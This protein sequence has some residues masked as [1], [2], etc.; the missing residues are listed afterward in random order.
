M[1]NPSQARENDEDAIGKEQFLIEE[2]EPLGRDANKFFN[3]L[4]DQKGV[5]L[6]KYTLR[7]L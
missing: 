6:E 3:F 5:E 4:Q 1:K 2:I 7:E